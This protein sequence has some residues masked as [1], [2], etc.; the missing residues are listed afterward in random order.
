[1]NVLLINPPSENLIRES[2]LT[3]V[4]D[5]TGV[6]PPLGLLYVASY[7]ESIPGC[8]VQL[9]DCQA[10]HCSYKELASIVRSFAPDV[11]GIQAMTFTMIDVLKVAETVKAVA[12]KAIVVAGGPHPTLYP[13]ETVNLPPID[14]VVYGEGELAFRSIL[15]RKGR[16]LD[17]ISSV[18]TKE[19]A[20][21]AELNISLQY[22]PDLNAL[23]MPSWHLL[24]WS[25]YYSPIARSRRVTTMMSSRG[26]PC[27]CTFCDR[28]QMGKV[29]RKRSAM[30]V[31]EE[32]SYCVKKFGVREIIF[33]DDTF[34]I[35]PDRVL[36]LCDI[37]EREKLQVQWDIRAR[38][39][40]MTPEMIRRLK[41]AG[42]V[43]IHYGVESGSARIQKSMKKNLNLDQVKEVFLATHREG[44]ETLGYFM[45]GLP[46]ETLE[47]VKMSFELLVNL[48][49]DFA[50]I[51]VFTPYPGTEIY[52][53]ALVDG[54]YKTDYWREFARNPTPG[55]VPK[56][57]NA[58]FSDEQLW[59]LLKQAHKL[60][61]R[62]PGYLFSRA[63]R[64][65][66]P[67]EFFRKAILGVKLFRE[68]SK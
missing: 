34:T 12:P 16:S 9:L 65:K 14:V 53:Q 17:G 66:S 10:E 35:D 27:R 44:I 24:H 40:T 15:E 68:V 32:M 3:V 45:I 33:Y 62:R 18:M 36:E 2:L 1:M 13:R 41:R 6:Y 30:N 4:E 11:V 8:R 55:F 25:R 63:L 50:N 5:C 64:I 51:T 46:S 19:T 59:A 38:V 61:Y 23:K 28:P 20:K 47:D 37:L 7:A 43:R 48:K 67:V 60:F 22:I 52:K 39:D 56:F 42:C 57:W 54:I 29:F 26:C 49:M 21:H 58:Y 31:F